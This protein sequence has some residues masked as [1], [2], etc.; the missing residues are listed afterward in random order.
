VPSNFFGRRT[1]ESFVRP[2]K[3]GRRSSRAFSAIRKGAVPEDLARR[4][5]T[6]VSGEKLMKKYDRIFQILFA[7]PWIVFGVQH[8][9]YAEFVSGLVPK[10]MPFGL[11][12][13]YFTGAA[14]I[15]AGISLIVN[16]LS[17]LAALL[18]GLMLVGFILLIHV[19]VVSASP[20]D[21]KIWTRPLQDIALTAA[22]FMLADRLSQ[23]GAENRFLANLA[24]ISRY[25]FALMLI[26]FGVQQLLDLDFLTAKIPL[27]MPLRSFW[28]YLT[29]IA[30]IATGASVIIDFK[31][32]FAAFALGI[33]L[34]AVNLLNYGYLLAT[35]PY[36]P[37][38]WTA[39]MLNL[40]LTAGVFILANSRPPEK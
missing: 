10:F 34:L 5:R 21:P 2:E 6:L 12:W 15:A 39:G 25:L 19:F 29:G 33:Y 9:K 37:Q 11:F 22:C 1:V 26:A 13:A 30:L 40:A 20:S 8:F 27:F 36:N 18:L 23:I 28:V 17:S 14:M 38:H 7:I 24:R 35:D 3:K 32:R 4:R 16:K 31:A